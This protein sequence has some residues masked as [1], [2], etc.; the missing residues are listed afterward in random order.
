MFICELIQR[1]N[2]VSCEIRAIVERIFK[3]PKI[4]LTHFGCWFI[5]HHRPFGFHGCSR[6]FQI[7]TCWSRTRC[8]KRVYQMLLMQCRHCK[9]YSCY[10]NIVVE[11]LHFAKYWWIATCLLLM[12]VGEYFGVLIFFCFCGWCKDKKSIAVTW[13]LD[14]IRTCSHEYV[15]RFWIP[16]RYGIHWIWD[17]HDPLS[18]IAFSKT[19]S[20]HRQKY[21]IPSN[22][23]D[24]NGCINTYTPIGCNFSKYMCVWTIYENIDIFS[25][26]SVLETC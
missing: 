22:H 10:H 17:G 2:Q 23:I 9:K 5:R 4:V 24:V 16:P 7:D 12:I 15:V 8:R 19:I 13:I 25:R 1:G 20:N 11:S 14:S 3:H 6:Q 21:R 18:D 26:L